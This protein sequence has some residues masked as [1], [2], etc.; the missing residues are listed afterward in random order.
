L[1]LMDQGM[2]RDD[3]LYDYKLEWGRMGSGWFGRC[4]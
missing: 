4:S 3:C 1:S 2:A